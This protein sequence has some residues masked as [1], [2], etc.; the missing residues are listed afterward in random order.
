[1]MRSRARVANRESRGAQC[2]AGRETIVDEDDRAGSSRQA[3]GRAGAVDVRAPFD[4][5][6]VSARREPIDET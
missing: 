3:A 1:M 4:L 5:G 6:R 2:R